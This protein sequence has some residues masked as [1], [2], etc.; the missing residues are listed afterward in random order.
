MTKT[1]AASPA[2]PTSRGGCPARRVIGALTARASIPYTGWRMLSPYRVIDLSDER[3]LLCGQILADLGADVVRV[4]PPGGSSARRLGPFAGDAADPERSLFWWAYARNTRS[5]VLDL[6]TAGG[7]A[8][9][10]R[11]AATADFLVESAGPGVMAR[12]GLD[13]AALLAAHPALIYVSL[14]PFGQDG[15]R[16]HEPGG[17]LIALAAGGVLALNGDADRAPVRISVPQADLHAAADAAT[18]ALIALHARLRDGRGQHVDAAAQHAVTLATQANILASAVGFVPPQRW[19]GGLRLGPLSSRLVYPARDGHVS[20]TFLFGSSIGPATRRLMHWIHD[21]GGCDAATRDK[22]WEAFQEQLMTG[23]ETFEEY[24]RVKQ[25]VAAFTRTRTKAELLEA[26]MRHHLLIAPVATP[27]EVADN[28]HF[29]ARGFWRTHPQPELAEPVRYPGPFARFSA[30]PLAYRRRPPRLGEHTAEVLA[31]AAGRAPAETSGAAA[32]ASA[33]A[34]PLA[35]VKVLDLMWAVAGPAATRM[36]ADFGATVVRVESPTHV[37]VCRTMPPFLTLP[38]DPEGS[39]LFHSVN[40]GKRLVTL[41]LTTEAGRAVLLDLVR[42]ADVLAE[43]FTPKVMRGWGLDYAVLRAVKP[44]LIM[45]STCLMG[46]SGPQASFA[47]YGNLAGAVTGFYELC[48]W[49]DRD[50][51]GPFGAYTDYIAPRYNAIAILAALEHRRR[52]GEGQHVDLSQAEAALHFLAPALLDYTVNG[53]SVSRAGNRDRD[54]VPHGVYPAAGDDAWVAIAVGDEAQWGALCAAIGQ[55]ALAADPRFATAAARQAHADA[56]D[57]PLA[58]WTAARPAEE[59]AAILR[60][61]GIAA[62]AVLTGAELAADPQLRHR[63][64]LV[65]VAHPHYATAV[66]EGS[67]LLLSRTPARRPD[68]A[69]LLGADSLHVLEEILGYDQDRITAA[70]AGGALG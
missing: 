67:R 35:G 6:D 4:E 47:G 61:A 34:A 19:A 65:P 37:D 69:P 20:I 25:V 18:G 5:A 36:L 39:A 31:E 58:A 17:D 2:R 41:D 21:Q 51:A 70:V 22:H 48:G 52:T 55:P 50:P 11:L 1:A 43:A 15:P 32:D 60:A 27:A 56:L 54:A 63:G 29:A 33:G 24:E 53:R 14:S 45:L 28:P 66:V 30:A 3:G 7:Q 62:A 9:L 40:A 12:R 57:A 49:P 44:D 23:E 38:P 59:T 46:Q 64:L 26:A 68:A 16:A 10:R 42:W 13:A 8:A